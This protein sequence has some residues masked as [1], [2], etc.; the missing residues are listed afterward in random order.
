MMATNSNETADLRAAGGIVWSA[1]A[2]ADRR[3]AIVHRGKRNDWALPKGKPEAGESPDQTA[4]REAM[5]ETGVNLRLGVFAGSYSYHVKDRLKVVE[6][7]HMIRLPGSCAARANADEIDAVVW[8]TPL[9]AVQRL[10]HQVERDF[11]AAHIG[12]TD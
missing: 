3:I 10:T 6:M 2:G 9:E 8:L 12:E 7:W 11:V 1:D 4:L 5:E